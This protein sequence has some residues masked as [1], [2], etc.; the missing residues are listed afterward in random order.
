MKNKVAIITGATMGIGLGIAEEFAKEKATVIIA[1]LGQKECEKTA[2]K[3]ASK[4]KTK[5]LGAHCDV[6][7]A[8]QIRNLIKITKSKF[9]KVDIFVNNAGIYP[10]KSINQIEE[11]DWDLV[12]DTNLKGSFFAIKEAA[13]IMKPG[14][15]ILLISHRQKE[16]F[17]IM[18]KHILDI[19][20]QPNKLLWIS[21]F[22]SFINSNFYL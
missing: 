4:Y 18:R 20:I 22:S 14:S 21:I 8:N 2:K 16:I 13:K 1:S 9:K 15:K 19:I 3:I 12:L 7:D 10:F 11:K 5:A 17:C 6:S